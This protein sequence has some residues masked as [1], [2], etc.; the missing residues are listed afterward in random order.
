[1]HGE[2]LKFTLRFQADLL[3]KY[4]HISM[5]WLSYRLKDLTYTVYG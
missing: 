5:P 3:H 4:I 1:M 2:T